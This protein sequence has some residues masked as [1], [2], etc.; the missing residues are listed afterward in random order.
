[1]NFSGKVILITGA[2]SGIGA[3]S[4]RAF[5]KLGAS[6]VIVDINENGLTSVFDEIKTAIG[7]KVFS[8]VA[9]VTKDSKKIIEETIKQFGQLDVLVNNAGISRVGFDINDYD[10]IH[11]VNVRSIIKLSQLAVPHLEKTN[12]NIVNVSSIAG[13]I[14]LINCGAYSVTK[15]AVNM[16]TQ[17]FATEVG[18]R[19]IRVNAVNPGYI[20]T[21]IYRTVGITDELWNEYFAQAAMRNAMKRIGKPSDISSAI[22]YLA[23][24]EASFVTGVLFRVDGGHA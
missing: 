23:S 8:I 16:F 12:G 19:G 1:M 20:E 11:D 13:M 24:D 3:E 17:Y 7:S 18:S 10:K 2:G 14:P 22:V 21:P 15:A 4:A 6:V 5:A 9:D